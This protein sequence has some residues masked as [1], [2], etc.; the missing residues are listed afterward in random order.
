M[1][2]HVAP[3][4]CMFFYRAQREIYLNFVTVPGHDVARITE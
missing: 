2:E 3:I 1:R 4:L